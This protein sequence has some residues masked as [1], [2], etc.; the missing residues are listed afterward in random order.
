MIP[1]H[2]PEL[3]AVNVLEIDLDPA[4]VALIRPHLHTYCNSEEFHTLHP[5]WPSDIEWISPNT[6]EMFAVYQQVFDELDATRTVRPLLDL[7]HAPRLYAGFLVRRSHCTSPNF[8]EDW[9]DTLHQAF[10]LITPIQLGDPAAG[11]L[12]KKV[13]GSEGRYPYRIGKGLIFGD[14]FLHSTEPGTCEPPVVLLSFT[15][16]TDRMCYWDRISRSGAYQ[17]NLVCCPDGSF[18]HR[19]FNS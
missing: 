2:N 18:L 10:T 5:P 8:H 7:Q 1:F 9:V 14:K 15:F 13:D 12:Y 16:G 4:V 11:L 19:S 17:G 6:L 3:D